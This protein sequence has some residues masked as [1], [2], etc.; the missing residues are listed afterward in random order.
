MYTLIIVSLISGGYT[1]VEQHNY[2]NQAQCQVAATT[3]SNAYKTL[4]IR[5]NQSQISCIQN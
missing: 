2:S 5:P 4:G 1:V 3:I